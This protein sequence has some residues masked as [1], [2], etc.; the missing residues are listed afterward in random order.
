MRTEMVKKIEYQKKKLSKR[1][2]KDKNGY[3]QDNIDMDSDDSS[4]E[5][6]EDEKGPQVELSERTSFNEALDTTT[7]NIISV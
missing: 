2:F 4:D 7:D 1:G 5:S 3:K 6:S